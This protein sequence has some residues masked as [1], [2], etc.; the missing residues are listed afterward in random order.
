MKKKDKKLIY[1]LSVAIFLI[2][3]FLVT[4]SIIYNKNDK[5]TVTLYSPI[6]NY[7]KTIKV[8]KNSDFTEQL[9]EHKI[10][11][12]EFLG[13][14]YDNDLNFKVEKGFSLSK[15]Q[16]LKA[17]YSKIIIKDE[18]GFIENLDNIESDYITVKTKNNELNQN[19]LD[20]IINKN[21]K[22]L[23][24]SQ[25]KIKGNILKKE[26]FYNNDK[27]E[28]ISLPN[29][30]IEIG[31]KAF[32]NCY[33]LKE[34]TLGEDLEIINNEAFYN[35]E[36]LSKVILNE[37]LKEIKK[38][39]FSY[40]TSLKELYIG[41]NL[42]FIGEK[43][44]FQTKIDNLKINNNNNYFSIDNQIL[45]SKN[46]DKIYYAGNDIKRNV[47]ISNNTKYIEDFA[48]YDNQNLESI[49]LPEDL[50]Y[51]GK[52][53]F[54]NCKN[55]NI[56]K[57]SNS[58]QLEIAEGAFYNCLGLKEIKFSLGLEI[59]GNEAFK[60]CYNL[61]IIEFNTSTNINIKNI[62]SIG[63]SCF[64]NCVSLI[65][66]IMP[67][68]VT[69]IGEES[70]YNCENL[71]QIDLSSRIYD[72]PEK[73][74]FNNI[75][76]LKVVATSNI[77]TIGNR[78]FENC[79]KL[80]NINTLT[81]AE[82]IGQSAFKNC[83]SLENIKFDYLNT[84]EE[85]TFNGCKSLKNISLSNIKIIKEYGFKNCESLLFFNIEQSL[86]EINPSAFEGCNKLESFYSNSSTKFYVED[87][88]IYD[89][90]FKYIICY[91]EGKKDKF[92]TIKENIINIIDDGI[93]LNNYIEKILVEE[94]NINYKSLDGILYN[95]DYSELIRYP[96]GKTL[97][98]VEVNETVK[99]IKNEAFCNNS[100][101]E[102]IIIKN[103]VEEIEKGAFANVNNLKSITLPFIG[104][105]L[106]TNKFI[107]YIFGSDSYY[108]NDEFVPKKLNYIEITND[109]IVDKY[110]FYNVSNIKSIIF[111]KEVNDVK[112]FAFYSAS[113]LE[114][115]VFN[116]A[117]TSFG[118]K[119][120]YNLIKL[121][122]LE[123]TFYKNLVL[124]NQVVGGLKYSIEVKVNNDNKS[125]S[126]AEKNSLKNK[127]TSNYNGAKNWKWL[128]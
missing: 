2:V 127:F 108:N 59:I 101:I 24:L 84:I 88:V 113:S 69:K 111:N 96:A 106:I 54:K 103:N 75:N 10:D 29:S 15:S 119:S 105:N 76:L 9:K 100:Y 61:K 77:K 22:Y 64:K 20:Y 112:E 62:S 30:I 58:K 118:E 18:N 102:N 104:Q 48:F 12:Y 98:T 74:F 83:E 35:C 4:F 21:P 28:F 80:N 47:V 8:E 36:S 44:F 17:G 38:E 37:K 124:K 117:I 109:Y 99:A 85:N 110:S 66:F 41:N 43:V 13:W 19:D 120:L 32:K 49:Y 115:I 34:V 94:K 5:I 55:L 114:K 79:K 31:E 71:T 53:A 50:E 89:S 65:S 7:K 125:I 86:E 72:I 25:S 67:D 3:V 90:Q 126:S 51:I 91:P 123:F 97:K 57:F 26:Q 60:N 82:I 14:F 128:F 78:A 40:C 11:G 73:S 87:G 70:F 1:S 23:D 6:D 107:G 33:F 39:A 92:F 45:T 16:V 42:E 27:I 93:Y 56:V 68:T 95:N 81:N 63:K 122:N 121:R 116:G 46:K 52:E